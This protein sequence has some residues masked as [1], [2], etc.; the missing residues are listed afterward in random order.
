[1]GLIFEESEDFDYSAEQEDRI[2]TAFKNNSIYG[3]SQELQTNAYFYSWEYT[4]TTTN[5]ITLTQDIILTGAIVNI[6]S[7]NAVNNN[8]VEFRINGAKVFE[9]NRTSSGTLHES[10]SQDIP[11]PNW[12]LSKGDTLSMV[13]TLAGA[14]S[15]EGRLSV[16]GYKI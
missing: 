10:L 16:K 4:A 15:G 6:V 14:G 3:R 8:S 12:R 2:D 5:T 9:F 7:F 13:Y 1:M 11:F